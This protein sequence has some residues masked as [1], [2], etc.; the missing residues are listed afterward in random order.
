[1]SKQLETFKSNLE[2]FASKHKQEIRKNS[3]FRLE[4]GFETERV[5]KGRGKYAQ[6]V[7]HRRDTSQ[8]VRSRRA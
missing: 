4:K 7:S 6:D 5:L 2:E 1:M 8:S 3:Q